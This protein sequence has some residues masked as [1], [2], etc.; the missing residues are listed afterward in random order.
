MKAPRD[1]GGRELG[2]RLRQYGYQL[3]RQEGSH[4]RFTRALKGTQHHVTIPD[5]DPLRIGTLNR[6]L[7]D[8]ATYLGMDRAALI[9]E[10][11]KK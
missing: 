8:V 7:S 9:Q 3:V 4:M 11:F 5:H 6:V 1:L 2:R 10:L